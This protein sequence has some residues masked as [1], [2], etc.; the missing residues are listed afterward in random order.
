MCEQYLI[1]VSISRSETKVLV[2]AAIPSGEPCC[3]IG[4]P[5]PVYFG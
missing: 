2:I 1:P 4:S 3:L 5:R